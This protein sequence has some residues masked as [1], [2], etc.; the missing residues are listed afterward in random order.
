ME[1]KTLLEILDSAGGE[2][3]SGEEL[4]AW[5]GV[6]RSAIWKGIRQLRAEG[7]DIRSKTNNGYALLGNPDLLTPKKISDCTSMAYPAE[8]ISV[9]PSVKSTNSL[10]RQQAMEGAPEGTVV[11]AEEQTGGR[12]RMGRSFLSPLG[13]LYMS[14]LIRPQLEAGRILFLTMIAALSVIDA[15][16]RLYG[17]TLSI[18]WVNDILFHGRKLSGIL[19][20]ASMDGESGGL[21][22]AAVGIGINFRGRDQFPTEIASTAA[23][24]EEVT[25][26]PLS[27]SKLCGAILDEFWDRYHA[28]SA[29]GE[30]KELLSRYRSHLCMLGQRIRVLSPQGEYHAVAKDIADNGALLVQ[31]EDGSIT[32]VQSGEIS[33]RPD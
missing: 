22:F 23:V 19:T 1:R 6:T 4:A 33:I 2:F 15:V 17:V 31:R 14:I 7:Y 5:L 28:F 24:L 3:I 18:K 16:Q 29:T 12:G 13:G 20:E 10:L 11:V 30:T 9:F 32:S 27:R 26:L 25:Q 21:E 8:R